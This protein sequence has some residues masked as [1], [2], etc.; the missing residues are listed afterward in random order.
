MNSYSFT[1]ESTRWWWPSATAGTLAAAAI[2]AILAVPAIGNAVPVETTGFE[3]PAAVFPAYSAPTGEG[4]RPCFMLRSRWSVALEGP[5]PT[6]RSAAFTEGP[7]A[8][9]VLRPW[10]DA[11][12]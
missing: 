1:S 10:L 5:Q 11:M 8:T 7:P 3:S 2:G 9:T 12:P 6:C 4:D